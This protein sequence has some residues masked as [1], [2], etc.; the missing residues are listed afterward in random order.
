MT[1]PA[2]F[3]SQDYFRNPAAAI[4]K[5][6]A[7]G[8]VVE[9]RFPII[10]KVWTPT[11][12]ALAD[13]VLKDTEPSPC[14]GT[15]AQ[16]PD[17]SGGCRVSCARLPQHVVDGRSGSQAV[18][19]YRRRRSGAAPCSTWSRISVLSRTNWPMNCLQKEARPT[20]SRACPQAAAIGDL[21]TSRAAARRPPNIHRLG[22]R[23]TRFTGMRSDSH[24]GPDRPCH[25][26]L[27]RT[28]AC[29]PFANGAARADR[30]ARAASKRT[31]ARSALTKSWPWYSCCCS[32]GTR[33]PRT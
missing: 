16:S 19:R 1:V 22:R 20:W 9:L 6:R 32:P 5:L 14:A 7:M 27:Y 12:Q 13:Q 18:A 11:T 17:S 24:F 25:E 8:P 29:R 2:D 28:P 31:A 3:A 10:G 26:A 30:R 23:F 21:R 33:P 15:T 4:E